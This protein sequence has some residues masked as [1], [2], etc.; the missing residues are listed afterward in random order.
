MS[1]VR[2][3][4]SCLLIA[5]Y[6]GGCSFGLFQTA[7]TQPPGTVSATLGATRISNELDGLAGRDELTQLGAEV[8]ARVGLTRRLELGLGSFFQSG[9]RA[10]AK[11]N[12]LDPTSP[13]ALAPRAGVG[14]AHRYG[15]VMAEGGAIASYRFFDRL[16]PYVGLT[17]ANHWITNYPPPPVVPPNLAPGSGSG[18]AL[19]QGALG[20]EAALGD[21]VALLAEYGHW[22][23]LTNDPGDFYAFVPTNVL[24]IALRVG[25]VRTR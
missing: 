13:F 15:V 14:Y 21:H 19:L 16:E 4:L 23:V 9:A 10:S 17:F 25:A 7:H 8:S 3:G 6:L 11:L 24:G 1:D 2:R 20:L 18:D 5:P 22:F 12:V